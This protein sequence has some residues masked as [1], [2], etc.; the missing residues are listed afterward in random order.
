VQLFGKLREPGVQRLCNQ[1]FYWVSPVSKPP[2]DGDEDRAGRPEHEN[3]AVGVKTTHDSAKG[4]M[5]QEIDG[6]SNPLR[7]R[8][9]L[10][11]RTVQP[12]LLEKTNVILK[13]LCL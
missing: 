7:V 11:E 6:K 5:G 3:P 8:R 10:C 12:W 4:E 1:A 2:A 13:N 9:I